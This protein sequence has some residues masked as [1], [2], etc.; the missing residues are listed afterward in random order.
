MSGKRLWTHLSLN[1]S[2]TLGSDQ[3]NCLLNVYLIVPACIKGT[4][5]MSHDSHMTQAHNTP[6]KLIREMR[7]SMTMKVPVRP[8][9]AEQWTTI[10]PQFFASS[11]VVCFRLT[12]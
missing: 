10:G 12:S 8:M 1:H 3:L 9:P 4:S 2:G 7:M 6:W 5:T 11:S